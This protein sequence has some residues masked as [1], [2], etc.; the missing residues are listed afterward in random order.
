MVCSTFL[1]FLYQKYKENCKIATFSRAAMASTEGEKAAQ[2]AAALFCMPSVNDI[3]GMK[4]KGGTVS[5]WKT[6]GVSIYGLGRD[7]EQTE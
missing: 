5:R 4:Q 6:G 3:F 7:C 1:L 2:I